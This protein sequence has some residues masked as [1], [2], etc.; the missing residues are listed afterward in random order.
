MAFTNIGAPQVDAFQKQTID[1]RQ[2][3]V[4]G[5]PPRNMFDVGQENLQPFLDL[6]NQQLPALEQGASVGGFFDD[7]N[8]LRPLV[9]SINQP[10][11]D[12]NMR[13]L[14]TSLGQSGLTRSGFAAQAAAD[15]EEDA[16]FGCVYLTCVA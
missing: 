11:I 13:D 2:P 8:A 7:A 4:P 16:D 5:E 1:G 15:V 3:V 12:E 14:N 9:S 10:I 6:G